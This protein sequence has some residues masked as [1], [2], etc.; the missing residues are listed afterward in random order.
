[1][2]YITEY[3]KASDGI[4]DI[5]VDIPKP[6]YDKWYPEGRPKGKIDLSC[7]IINMVD[8]RRSK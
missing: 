5:R 8:G 4:T 3:M 1:M 6:L 2:E 7:F